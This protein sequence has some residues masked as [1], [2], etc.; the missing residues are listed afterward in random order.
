MDYNRSISTLAKFWYLKGFLWPLGGGGRT[1]F[2][3][4]YG[5]I[6]VPQI[7][8]DVYKSCDYGCSKILST[9]SW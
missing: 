4:P 6:T 7:E 1:L 3:D 8:E 2:I 5:Q 9:H